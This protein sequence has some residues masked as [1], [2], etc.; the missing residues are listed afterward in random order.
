MFRATKDWRVDIDTSTKRCGRC[1]LTVLERCPY[2]CERLD[3][4]KLL[5]SYKID[6]TSLIH[7][8]ENTR[9]FLLAKK[10]VIIGLYVSCQSSNLST[11]TSL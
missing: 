2:V 11:V 7:Q 8:L 3:S 9:S 5:L 4:R 6:N 10:A 1:K